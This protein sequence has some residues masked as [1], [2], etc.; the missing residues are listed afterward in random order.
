[1]AWL[2]SEKRRGK[3]WWQWRRR[4]RSGWE[5]TRARRLSEVM[6]MMMVTMLMWA[7][8]FPSRLLVLKGC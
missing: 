6:T 1:M 4:R 7:E 8:H 3:L 2:M 5:E